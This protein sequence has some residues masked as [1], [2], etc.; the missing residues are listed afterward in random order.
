MVDAEPEATDLEDVELTPEDRA[1]VRAFL[2]RCDVRLSTIHRVATALLSGAGLLVLLPAVERDSVVVVLRALLTGPT[3]GTHLL[4]VIAVTASLAVPFTA[5]WLVV[6]DLTQF[7]F[8][9]NHIRRGG[10]EA[11]APRFTL[12]GIQLPRGELHPQAAAALDRLR[13][14]PE[15]VEILV[16]RN[17]AARRRIDAQISAYGGLGV[18][19][20]EGDIGR[21]AALFELAASR[22]RSLLEEVTKVEHGMTRHIL[23][24]QVIVL[25]YAKALLALL[26]TAFA[27]FAS[28]AVVADK[29]TLAPG[30]EVWL[31]AILLAWA[32]V[33]ITAVTSPVRWLEGQ[34]RNEGA[35][36]TAVTADPELTRVEQ[37]TVR[38]ALVGH[39]AAA[40]AMIVILTRT[41]ID[42]T[43]QVL[44]L[45]ALVGASAGVLSSLR[46]WG[47]RPPLLHL[48]RSPN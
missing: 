35:T 31:A 15:A 14:S 23:R 46:S 43:A 12:T 6:R 16:P 24:M 32:P 28:A 17:D 20:D 11:F 5:L 36:H 1:A 2:Q 9:A 10:A 18:E 37:V 45:A 44:G 29:T 13:R 25:R 19:A 27:A 4:L 39:L 30:D 48:V 40:I 34:L 42:G 22:E 41:G 21:A 33:A 3:D 38:L 8:H 26:T 47:G 7:Y